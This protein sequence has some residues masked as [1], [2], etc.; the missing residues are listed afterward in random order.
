VYDVDDTF[1]EL[2]LNPNENK[3]T[4]SESVVSVHSIVCVGL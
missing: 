3:N 2:D 1:S 4:F